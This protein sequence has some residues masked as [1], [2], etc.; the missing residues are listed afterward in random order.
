MLR[1]KEMLVRYAL[2]ALAA[3]LLSSP[4]VAQTVDAQG[5]TQL[6][7]TLSRYLSKDAFGKGILK[8]SP[9]GDAYK[10]DFDFKALASLAPDLT[11]FKFEVSPYSV[12][13]KP[14]ADGTWQVDGALFPNGWF[15]STLP[16]QQMRADW[17]VTDGKM[18]GIF[19]PA[20][21]AFSTAMGRF[22]GMTMTTKDQITK[23]DASYGAGTMTMSATRAAN[24][25]IDFTLQQVIADYV[26]STMMTDPGSGMNFPVT[27]KM[28]SLGSDSDGKGVKSKAFLDALAFFVANSDEQKIKA[29]QLQLRSILTE[30]M[31][32]WDHVT[33]AYRLSGLSVQT[34]VG[35]FRAGEA[36]LAMETDGLR[37][38]AT[39]TYGIR[40]SD[41]KA[42]SLFMPKWAPP[43]IPTDVDIKV[44]GVNLNLEAPAKKAIESFDLDQDPPLPAK[45]SEEI[46]AAFAANPPKL[47][48][49]KSTISNADTAFT[50]QGEVTYPNGVGVFDITV[51]ATGFDKVTAALQAAGESDPQAS[52][53][54]LAAQMAQG[55]A[56]PQPDGR[57][58]WEIDGK[59]DGSV[60]INGTMVK[61]ADAPASPQP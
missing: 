55:L 43:L 1:S 42:I 34:P 18:S 46:V 19:D 15:E 40:M 17:S 33:G 28:A 20:L 6:T 30:A 53:I 49:P 5:A 2:P 11:A 59:E 60:S 14:Q 35:E 3:V 61:P 16:G 8:V 12:R 13:V 57:L 41:V 10:I 32:L 56:R 31:P 27:V 58:V 45:V 4:A 9:D 50:A 23:S 21:S 7:E 44:S 36:N 22:A 29:N 38:N 37:Q 24:G 39:V 25:G 26:A 48:I 51:D 52:Q 47:V 54:L